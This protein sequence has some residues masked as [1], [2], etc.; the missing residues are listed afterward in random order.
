MLKRKHFAAGLL[1][2][3]LGLAT[4]I[5]ADGDPAL[6]PLALRC[7]YLRNPQG[8]DRA[9]PRLSWRVESSERG[10][11]QTAY[12]VLVASSAEQLAKENG[13]LWDSGRLDSS[14]TTHIRYD[15][16]PLT[17]RQQCYWKVQVWDRKGV[18][19]AWS[20]PALWSMGLLDESDW[21]AQYVSYRDETPVFKD[22]NSLFLPPAHYFRK[23]FVAKKTIKRATIYAT[24]L[25]I[26]ELEL[27]GRRVGDAFFA[28]GWTDY[29]Q[30]AYY[31][32]YDVTDLI[33][34]GDNAIGATVADGWYSGY[35][36]Y[37]L[38]VGIGTERIGR[39]TY[40]KTPAL[41]AQLELEYE[42][43]SHQ[44]IGTDRSWRVSGDGP[45]READLLMGEFYDARM[46]L[47]AWSRAG[48]DDSNWE[49]AI[50][51]EENGNPR[52]TFYA[53]EPPT[54]S[55]RSPQITGREIELGF[56]RP[57]LEAFPGVPVRVI[58]EIRSIELT[59]RAESTYIFDLGQ[60]FAGTVRLKLTGPA[61]HRVTL[62][63]GEML[64]PDGRLMT[65]NLRKARATDYY[66]CRGDE[67][68]E[69]YTPRF[70][71]HGFQYVEVANYPGKPDLDT[72]TGLALHSDTP[73]TSTFECSDPMVN[74]LFSNVV[75]TQRANF[76][77]LPTDCPQRDERMGWTG[78][79]QVYVA[80]A[81][82]N[83]DVA[84]FYTKWLRELMESQRP[85]GAFPG[86]APFPFHRGWDFGTAWADAGII[87]PWTIW[88]AYG[89]T[90]V[91]DRCWEPMTRFMQWRKRTSVDDLGI[92]HG[93]P[94]GDWLAQGA[95]T[96]LDYIDSVYFAI[97]AN[98]MADMAAATGRDAEAR[99][100]REQFQR[101][102]TAFVKKYVNR[103]GS[104]IVKTQTAYALAL[105]ADLVP[106][107]MHRATGERLAELIRTNGNRMATGFLGTRPL[108]PVLSAVGQ[109]DLAVFLLQSREFPSWGYEIDQGATSIWERWDSYTKED[110]FGRHNAAMNSFAHYSF[111]AVCEWM[112]RTL[113]GIESDGPGY[114]QI[115]I[116]PS[117][118]SPGSNAQH[119]PIDWVRASYD[120]I[121]GK[122]V[123]Q[124]KVD[125]DRFC[126]DTTIPTNTTATVFLPA[127][128]ADSVTEAGKPLT[129][130]K[131]LRVM[132]T[133]DGRVVLALESGHYHFES[134]GGICPADAA[135]KTSKP[136]DQSLN[137]ESIDL[138]GAREVVHWD[139]HKDQDAAQWSTRHNL[140]LESRGGKTFLVG[141]GSD[142]QLATQLPRSLTGPLAVQLKA[143]PAKGT[144]AQFFWASPTG[145][146]NASQ[147]NGRQLNPADQVNTYLFRIGDG[148]PLQKLRFD[149]F[150]NQ[151]EMQVES[152]AIY[153]LD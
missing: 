63:Y 54:A 134:T 140:K 96:P 43:G 58:E 26:Y 153:Q 45:I 20:Q 111:G 79:A 42:D 144:T 29:R 123:S 115:I 92:V 17:S 141:T 19:S 15:G 87:C 33:Q 103:D 21:S 62:R 106:A 148:G 60:N 4:A 23:E 73:L 102:K 48:F 37:G 142:P 128:S 31:N 112:F 8:I 25:G 130:A 81:T 22:R 85:S 132:E 66:V 5:A 69:F 107:E 13:D 46:E 7:E 105:Y 119:K 36:A 143:R 77:D 131:Q 135:L 145:G 75:W 94:W 152:L 39:Y 126:L 38:L 16:R 93:N 28:P 72:L 40:G 74:Q 57:R 118:P 3:L 68:G 83:A 44:V 133:Q 89:D 117:P 71:F 65:E 150:S 35:V 116:R 91:I 138:A 121:H 88:Q 125:G 114:S 113:A 27:N 18:A 49:A 61:G 137:P 6:K 149:P 47:P 30:R 78:D 2:V 34:Q 129:E 104:I 98:M 151:G 110:G 52:A 12:R 86:F 9:A 109:H 120:S 80:T 76:V 14:R 124:W 41:M 70:T 139:F 108:L 64:H 11:K 84:A 51:A 50:G 24:A 95:K 97:T 32:T 146:F 99:A 59:K 101:T 55:G 56:R 90:R 10:Q 67:S 136:A 100:Y 82:Y 53:A 147:Q 122:I 1:L 127:A